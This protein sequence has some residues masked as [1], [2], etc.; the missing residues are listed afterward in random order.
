MINAIL[1]GIFNIVISL[2]NLLLSGID[3]I[4][5][6][7]MPSVSEALDY[8]A[9][10]FDY[11]ASVIP[12]GVSWLGLDSTIIGIFVAYMTFKLTAPL[13]VHTIKLAFKWYNTLKL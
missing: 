3:S 13:A 5:A 8:V 11:A 4:I 6:S 7:T 2:V 12:W 9:T 10:F 1:E